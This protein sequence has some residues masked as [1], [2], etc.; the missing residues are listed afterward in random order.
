LLLERVPAL[1]L[2]MLTI[3]RRAAIVRSDCS[4]VARRNAEREA[5][6]EAGSAETRKSEAC[7]S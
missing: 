4:V 3:C 1:L 7:D 2:A 6:F 5:V